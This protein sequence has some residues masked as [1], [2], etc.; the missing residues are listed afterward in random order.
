MNVLFATPECAP[1]VKTGGLGDVSAALPPALARL[2]ADVRVLMPAYGDMRLAGELVATWSLPAAGD[3]PAAQLLQVHRSGSPALLLLSCPGLYARGGSPYGDAGGQDFADNARR[4]GLLSRV[5]ALLGTTASPCGWRADVVHAN[6]WPCGLA[7]LFLRQARE[8]TGAP[9]AAGVLTVHNLA[10]QGLFPL[11]ACEALGV[12][13]AHRGIDGLEFWGQGSMLKAGLQFADAIT[14]VS[15]RYAHEIQTEAEGFGLDG[16]L[17]AQAPRL[18]GILNGIDT[19]V[20]DPATDALITE[21]YGIGRLEAKAVNK[22][23]LQAACGLAPRRDRPLFGH[24][25]RLTGQKGVDLIAAGADALVRGGAQLVVLGSGEPALQAALSE[26]AARHPTHIHVHLGFDETLAHQIVA[27]ADAF[28]MPSRFEPCGLTQM[29]SQAYGTPPV[30]TPVGGL[31]DTVTDALS[32]GG[33]F[34]MAGATQQ[35]FDDAVARALSLWAQPRRWRAIQRAGMARDFGWDAPA[36]AYL[37]VYQRV[38]QE[39]GMGLA[40]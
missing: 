20:W 22:T 23:A 24:V 35:A 30:V 16:V 21:R 33:G 9:V 27:G 10:F 31:A 37:D 28:L 36:R 17:R 38:A 7:P 18:Q 12:A 19:A 1:F 40:P 3:W 4:F 25:G 32:G 39:M 34:V 2:G 29:Y 6:D 11:A 15:P 14:T 26:A 8:A 13:P 5:A